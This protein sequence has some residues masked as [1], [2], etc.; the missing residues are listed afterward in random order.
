VRGWASE[1]GSWLWHGSWHEMTADRCAG[2][3]TVNRVTCTDGPG[4][5]G[6][7][8]DGISRNAWLRGMHLCRADPA[9]AAKC[10]RRWRPHVGGHC[11]ADRGQ[12]AWRVTCRA[13]APRRAGRAV[14]G[15]VLV[16]EGRGA[17]R[18]E[19][20]AHTNGPGGW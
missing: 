12:R 6:V 15:A 8:D 17:Q 2:L 18:V 11:G 5:H 7:P 4:E 9:I 3:S 16:G 20:R 13:A 1:P 14:D 10:L 19:A